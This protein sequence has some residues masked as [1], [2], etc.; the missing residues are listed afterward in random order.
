[1]A[2]TDKDIIH[3]ADLARLDL[4]E[5]EIKQVGA[6]LGSILEYVER[7]QKI[8]TRT[9]EP[10]SMP[11]REIGWR[12]DK[13]AACDEAARELILNNFPDRQDDLLRVPPVFEKP[14]G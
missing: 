10:Q 3:L 12:E 4:T 7:L 6:E 8:D 5:S 1:M 13:A 2:I 14:K 9:V 11:A